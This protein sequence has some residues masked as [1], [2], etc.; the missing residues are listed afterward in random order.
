M[1]SFNNIDR[2]QPGS[3]RRVNKMQSIG[4]TRRE[5]STTPE[6][7]LAPPP[8]KPRLGYNFAV[9][10]API[11]SVASQATMSPHN[12]LQASHSILMQPSQPTTRC[13]KASNRCRCVVDGYII[14]PEIPPSRIDKI[15]LRK[16]PVKRVSYT[17]SRRCLFRAKLHVFKVFKAI[18]PIMPINSTYRSHTAISSPSNALHNGQ[19]MYRGIAAE[20]QGPVPSCNMEIIVAAPEAKEIKPHPDPLRSHPVVFTR[21]V[22][23]SRAQNVAGPLRYHNERDEERL[24]ECR[25]QNTAL[26]AENKRALILAKHWQEAYQKRVND[27]KSKEPLARNKFSKN[28][29]RSLENR[30]RL[31]EDE[32]VVAETKATTAIA[33][34]EHWKLLSDQQS[35]LNEAAIA[36]LEEMELMD[37]TSVQD[38]PESTPDVKLSLV[39]P[40]PVPSLA[41][42]LAEPKRQNIVSPK[43]REDGHVLQLSAT[44]PRELIKSIAAAYQEEYKLP[45]E[46]AEI[47]A[48]NS[49][50]KVA[51][52]ESRNQVPG[53]DEDKA[54]L[55]S[56][57]TS[58]PISSPILPSPKTRQRV[59]NQVSWLSDSDSSPTSARSHPSHETPYK[60]YRAPITISTSPRS[61][62]SHETPYK[63]YRVPIPISTS[64]RSLPSHETSYKAYRVPIPNPALSKRFSIS[65]SDMASPISPSST[66]TL[67]SAQNRY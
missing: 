22:G 39:I 20:A 17:R 57:R 37:V 7:A 49:L 8:I 28:Q 47:S 42:V 14:C 4:N 15:T 48:E 23:N 1:Q 13:G 10:P 41:P 16:A 34:S 24:D 53:Q 63:A 3:L 51:E 31:L 64:P 9:Q 33:M 55:A 6:A 19:A 26:A 65:S 5:H 67:R 38:K 12:S 59:R 2:T 18:K 45:T 27:G 32:K 54:S 46:S 58:P 50:R 43:S 52:A 61:H 66:I 25:W 35:R 56:D 44:A 40:E 62:P 11:S 29:I 60:A 36:K 30:I 21:A